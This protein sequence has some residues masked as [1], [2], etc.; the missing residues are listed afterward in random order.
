[1]MLSYEN[2]PAM[3]RST[4]T[5]SDLL[6]L[7]PS[8]SNLTNGSSL[9]NGHTTKSNQPETMHHHIWLITGPAGCGKS[10]VAQFIAKTMN[11]PYIEGDE[12]LTPLPLSV[13]PLTPRSTT[14]QQTSTRWQ[15]AYPS[16][17]PIDGTG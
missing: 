14:Q 13:I 12:V 5:T 10:T 17:T 8:A 6:P 15:R 2:R 7:S 9:T 3:A 11:L 4:P 16:A 1:M